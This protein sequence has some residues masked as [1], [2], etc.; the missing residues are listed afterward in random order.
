[1]SQGD[2]GATWKIPRRR[3]VERG[4]T[5]KPGVDIFEESRERESN[6]AKRI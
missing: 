3:R 2:Q 1:M 5:R 4:S 6:R